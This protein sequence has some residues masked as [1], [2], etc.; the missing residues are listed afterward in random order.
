MIVAPSSSSCENVDVFS[1]HYATKYI[2]PLSWA[3]IVL[4]HITKL[5]VV[6]PSN[7]PDLFAVLWSFVGCGFFC[8]SYLVTIWVMLKMSAASERQ[9]TKIG[10]KIGKKGSTPIISMIGAGL[11]LGLMPT[12]EGFVASRGHDGI[13]SLAVRASKSDNAS[14][15]PQDLIERARVPLYWET[16]R[17]EDAKPYLDLSARDPDT[18]SLS[19][20]ASMKKNKGADEQPVEDV[21]ASDG[22][23][24]SEW[25]DGCNWLETK[26]QLISMGVLMNE[27]ST[28]EQLKTK[29]ITSEILLDRAPQLF[30]LPT[31][32]VVESTEFFVT[33]GQF[34]EPLI[35]YDPSV[36]TYCA[37]DLYYGMEYLS[38]M[39]TRGNKTQAVQMIQMQ[40]TIAPS[41]ALSIFRMGVDGG[42]DERRIANAL[43]GAAKASGKALEMAVG[44]AGRSYREFKRLKGGKGSLS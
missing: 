4:L 24:L 25:E 30:R 9:N 18:L 7:L 33:Q 2:Q 1:A 40:C 34:L 20:E 35:Q 11:L 3:V 37:D 12:S 28:S 32:N 41:M 31:S 43:G 36:L 27:T 15:F 21:S 23:G 10:A 42:I 17:I 38:N 19:E 39:M 6:P 44:D 26:N 8:F 13:I 14:G 16:Q 29:L 22:A 5:L